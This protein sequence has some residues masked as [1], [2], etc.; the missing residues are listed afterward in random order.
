[1]KGQL[2]KT[3]RSYVKSETGN[4][5]WK[6]SVTGTAEEI[7]AFEAAQDKVVYNEED[8]GK[9][10]FFSIRNYGES[11]ELGISQS[12]NIYVNTEKQDALKDQ[13]EAMGPE[14]AKAAAAQMVAQLL[15]SSVSAP[16]PVNET[17]TTDDLNNL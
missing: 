8:G 2:P 10:I 14:F 11:V 15:G 6:Y 9:P 7:A 13:I 17:E 3:N 5:V 1:M 4:R 12:G 16:A